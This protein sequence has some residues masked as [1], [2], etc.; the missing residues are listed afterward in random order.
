MPKPI[1]STTS[2]TPVS[3][4][5][6]QCCVT[7]GI[8]FTREPLLELKDRNLRVNFGNTAEPFLTEGRDFSYH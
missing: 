6:N 8:A 1:A 4:Q 5:S 2:F 7:M 3:L